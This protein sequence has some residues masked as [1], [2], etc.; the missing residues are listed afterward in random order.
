LKNKFRNVIYEL[1]CIQRIHQ[2]IKKTFDKVIIDMGRGA[3]AHGQTYVA[4]S[5][6]TS[7][8]GIVLKKPIA[9]T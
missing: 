2:G 6:C 5:R 1:H 3:F 7:L 4:L 9:K 8:Q